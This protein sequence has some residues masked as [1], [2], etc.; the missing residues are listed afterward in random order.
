MGRQS[1]QIE[2]SK[3]RVAKRR[4]EGL[5][6]LRDSWV[7]TNT[8]R[9]DSGQKFTFTTKYTYQG[10]VK[11]EGKNLE[12]IVFKTTDVDYSADADSPITVLQSDLKVTASE[13]LILFDPAFGQI[14]SEHNKIQIK[15]SLKLEIKEKEFPG[16]LDLTMEFNTTVK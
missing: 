9:F 16:K 8:L 1:H 11:K 5:P 15:G 13:G 3:P 12:K 10:S 7:L 2:Q 14:I 4:Q 6:F